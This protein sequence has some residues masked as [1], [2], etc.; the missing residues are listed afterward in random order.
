MELFSI[1]D[2]V[3]VITGGGSGIGLATA[4]RFVA[5]GAKVLITNRRDSS[6]LAREQGFEFARADVGIEE[7]LAAA[8]DLI[9]SRLR[10]R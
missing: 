4:K 6:D 9:Q 1:R 7:A 2:K 8:L 5:A 3:A 10:P